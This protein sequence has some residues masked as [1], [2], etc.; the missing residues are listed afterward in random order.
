MQM[1][2]PRSAKDRLHTAVARFA[3]GIG[4]REARSDA[5]LPHYLIQVWRPQTEAALRSFQGEYGLPVTG[6][7]DD[8][9]LRRLQL[10]MPGGG[11]PGAGR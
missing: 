6:Q 9:T 5:G 10:A 4:G 11:S 3:A 7:L 2:D 8:A 1:I